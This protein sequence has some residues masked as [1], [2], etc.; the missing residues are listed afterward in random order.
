MANYIVRGILIGGS[1]GV[2]GALFGLV[3]MGRGIALGMV[4]GFVAGLTLAKKRQ[5]KDQA[6]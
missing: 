4:G 5:D 1:L 2:F 3:D 6:P